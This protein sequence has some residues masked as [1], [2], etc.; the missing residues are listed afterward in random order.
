MLPPAPIAPLDRA[1]KPSWA[2]G[3]TAGLT[4]RWG[5]RGEFGCKSLHEYNGR[6]TGISTIPPQ[7]DMTMK[8]GGPTWAR[9]AFPAGH[10]I[11]LPLLGRGVRLGGA[12]C[13]RF[14]QPSSRNA[15]LKWQ[16]KS[17]LQPELS[18]ASFDGHQ[19]ALRLPQVFTCPKHSAHANEVVPCRSTKSM[20]I[21]D[22]DRPI[23]CR[24]PHRISLRWL[25][26]S[27]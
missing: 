27:G 15:W 21:A 5:G 25:R 9:R 8:N 26:L 20:S 1:Y 19:F 6:P 2:E 12:D 17:I 22:P 11:G 16:L 10:G 3:A 18:L 13:T 4:S 23:L 24:G 7:D 14:G